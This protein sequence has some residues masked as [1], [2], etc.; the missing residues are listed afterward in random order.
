MSP[1]LSLAS[2]KQILKKDEKVVRLRVFMLGPSGVGKTSLLATMYDGHEMVATE[3]RLQLTPESPEDAAELNRKVESLKRHYIG[4]GYFISP[5]IEGDIDISRYRFRLGRRGKKPT[6]SLEFIDI[7]GGLVDQDPGFVVSQL[8]DCDAVLIPIDAPALM[9]RAGKW[10]AFRNK[11]DLIHTLVKQAYEDLRTPRLIILCP[12]R[13]ERYLN[14]VEYSSQLLGNVRTGYVRLIEY[15]C[16]GDLRGYVSL[17][18]VPVQTLGTIWYHGNNDPSRY[19]PVF[20]KVSETA[21]YAP[22]DSE[23]PLR[24]VLRFAL[25]MQQEQRESGY[26]SAIRRMFGKD[27]E[28]LDAAAAF[29][30]A[31]KVGGPFAIIQG[32]RWLEIQ[33]GARDAPV[34][35]Q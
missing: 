2:F 34:R 5:G 3:S 6:V 4:D 23:Q 13:G 32:Q 24:Y 25:H 14:D 31:T 28:F 8:R 16:D 20:A 18:V 33:G 21:K 1:K 10:H 29:S 12:I 9:E 30:L 35:A 27:R 11:P 19:S 26:F 17:A 15:L 22:V 7:P